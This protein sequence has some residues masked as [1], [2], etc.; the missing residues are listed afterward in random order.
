MELC[1]II[2]SIDYLMEL[3]FILGIDKKMVQKQIFVSQYFS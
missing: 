1:I 2:S 3:F